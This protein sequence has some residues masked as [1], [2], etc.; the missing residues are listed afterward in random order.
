MKKILIIST[1]ILW[2]NLRAQTVIAVLDNIIDHEHQNISPYLYTNKKE[3]YNNEDDD[4]NGLVDD[5]HGWNFINE[6]EQTFDDSERGSFSSDVFKYYFV[7]KKKTLGTISKTELNWYNKIRKNDEFMDER[8]KFSKFTHGSHVAC[9]AI[10]KDNYPKSVR[11]S[12]VKILPL[13][14]LGDAKSGTFFMDEFKPINSSYTSKKHRHIRRYIDRYI[15]Y[16]K[17]KFDL[18]IS[19]ATK[20]AHI[21]NASWAQSTGSTTNLIDRL[22][23][24]QFSLDSDD[25]TSYKKEREQ[26]V[27]YFMNEIMK[28]GKRVISKYPNHLF[29]FSAGNKKENTDEIIHYPSGIIASNVISVGAYQ[30]HEG[31]LERAYFSN[32]GKKT[33]SISAPGIA[34]KSCTPEG[35]DIPINGTSQAAPQ[36]TKAAAIVREL[37]LKKSKN[38]KGSQIKSII[39]NSG[40]FYST[41]KDS[42]SSSRILDLEAAIKLAR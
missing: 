33:V 18:S 31:K 36:V 2:T 28:N 42:S 40:K 30:T 5:V 15:K 7:R 41:L 22:Y 24:E 14:Y 11:K 23:R 39:I 29:V 26:L 13:V 21:I 8:K 34:I 9:L 10:N 32:Y 12:E 19:Y 27:H 17:R 16:M 20:H 25:E 37:L 1:L 3:I 6:N 4:Y 38:I 35:I